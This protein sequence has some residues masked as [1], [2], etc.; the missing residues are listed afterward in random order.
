M[1]QN[2]G[3]R[4]EFER[5]SDEGM[6]LIN[7]TSVKTAMPKAEESYGANCCWDGVVAPD[8]RFYYPLSSENGFCLNTKLG[9]F[10]YDEGKVITCFDAADVLLHPI[11]KL[12]HAKFHTSLNIIPR[13]AL[14]PEV[15]DDPDDY[16][17]VGTT[18]STDRAPH[19][20]E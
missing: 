16:L 7:Q 14:Y 2:T 11:R 4:F 3:K 17:V 9:Y 15:P 12:P 1:S 20:E 6:R 5:F 19:H 10:D 8:G 13:H 18:H